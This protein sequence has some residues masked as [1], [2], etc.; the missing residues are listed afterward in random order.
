MILQSLAI[1]TQ[2]SHDLINPALPQEG[3][4]ASRIFWAPA[5]EKASL[6]CKACK[7]E[8]DVITTRRPLSVS[9]PVSAQGWEGGG[10]TRA[11]VPQRQQISWLLGLA[12]SLAPRR[13]HILTFQCLES[14]QSRGMTSPL[15][16]HEMKSQAK[17]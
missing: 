16:C 17:P 10:R 1:H 13:L 7:R 6:L 11:F 14:I 9:F 5:R 8:D 3:K 4:Q 15:C 2:F 12:V